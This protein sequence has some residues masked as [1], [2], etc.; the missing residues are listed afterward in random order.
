MPQKNNE[1]TDEE[2]NSAE[3]KTKHMIVDD[4][5]IPNEKYE[6][7][8]DGT[9]QMTTNVLADDVMRNKLLTDYPQLK[10]LLRYFPNMNTATLAYIKTKVWENDYCDEYDNYTDYHYK[11]ITFD[12]SYVVRMKYIMNKNPRNREHKTAVSHINGNTLDNRRC[13]LEWVTGTE[14]LS[15][16]VKRMLEKNHK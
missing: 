6:K 1:I 8:N 3:I 2:L 12:I 14:N 15:R 10:E 11:Q 4:E 5:W 16:C 9:I 7:L 13:N